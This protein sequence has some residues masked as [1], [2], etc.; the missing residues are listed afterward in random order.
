VLDESTR[1]ASECELH[2]EANVRTEHFLNHSPNQQHPNLLPS[3][4]I[5]SPKHHTSQ[6]SPKMAFTFYDSSILPCKHV[7]DDLTHLIE[8]AEKHPN[9]ST[10]PSAR[11]AEDMRPFSSQIHLAAQAIERLLCRLASREH[12]PVEDTIQ[13]YDDM[14]QRIKSVHAEL[15]ATDK[16][17]IN[18]AGDEVAPTPLTPAMTV[19]MSGA[20]FAMGASMPNIFFH[21]SIAYAILRAQGVPL[22]K[23]DYIQPFMQYQL[24]KAA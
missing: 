19:D 17:V 9:A 7:L 6:S 21:L 11:L 16:D 24:G 5:P 14:R 1:S 3:I 23:W 12:V 20:N 4:A 22:G 8:L 13:T 2:C 15:D 10:L 18:R